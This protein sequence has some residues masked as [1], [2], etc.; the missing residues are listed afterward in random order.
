MAEVMTGLANSPRSRV[1]YN[2]FPGSIVGKTTQREDSYIVIDNWERLG[3]NPGVSGLSKSRDLQ[4]GAWL[5]PAR[6]R[7]SGPRGRRFKS[8]RP[9]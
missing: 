2:V 3:Y 9:D 7:G 8:A 1:D 6:A 4:D 5:S